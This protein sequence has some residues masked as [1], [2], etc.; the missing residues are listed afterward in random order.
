MPSQ[1]D[2]APADSRTAEAEFDAVIIGAGFSGLYMLQRLRELGL[3]AQVYEAGS[4]V[5][6]TWY[7]NRYPGARSD[8]DSTVYCF[9]DKF[10]EELLRQWEWSERYPSQPEILRYL[11]WVADKLD[12]RRDIHCGTRVSS[13]VYDE[14]TNRWRVTTEAGEQVSARVFIPAVGALSKPNVP[15]FEGLEDFEGQW[16]HTARM[17]PE[18]VNFAGK[19]VAV[20]GN[21]ATAVQ[22]VPEVA[23]EAAH[24]WEFQRNPYHCIPGRNHRLDADDWDEI[25]THHKEIWDKARNNF[26]GFPYSDFLGLA[27]EFS[28]KER[29]RILEESWMKGGFPIAFTFADVLANPETNEE[30][31]AFLRSKIHGIVHNPAVADLLMP[32]VPFASKRMPIE[33]GYYAAFNRNNVTLV[34]MK[35]SPIERITSKGIQT[36]DREYEVDIIVMA[37]GFDGYTGSLLAMDI[38]GRNGQQLKER[39]A[40]ELRTY[41]GL[42]VSGFPNM[43]LIYC[44]PYNPAILANAPTLIEQQGE[45]IIRCLKYLRTEAYDYIEALPES[46][47]RFLK[48]HREISNATLIPQTD[49]WWTGANVKGKERQLLSWCGGFPAYD[50]LCDE[51]AIGGYPG[52][53]LRAPATRAKAKR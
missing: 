43:F 36:S 42:A 45:W 5:G 46:E 28:P 24:V 14:A 47:E 27:A 16:F 50:R 39:W 23:R 48:L 38:R 34:D 53:I 37:T 1:T 33:H 31:M 6:G 4:D 11:Q 35:S 9:S 32:K 41:L 29:Q 18:G 40:E 20:I 21:G 17:P 13:A 49:S 19:R 44:G 52:F 30:Y 12:L 3:T 8:S 26:A 7:W 2:L 25:H 15:E 22:V 10:S 51:E